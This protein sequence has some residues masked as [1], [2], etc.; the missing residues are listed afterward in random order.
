MSIA[1]PQLQQY[2]FL[3][4]MQSDAYFPPFLVAK[5]RQILIRLCE[6]IEAEP[7]PSLDALYLLTHAAT[8]EF[9]RLAAEFERH[10]S[11]IETAAR[12]NI[13]GDFEVI[14]HAY[15]FDSAD[16]EELIA[17]RDW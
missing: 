5:G 2:D 8:E 10:D 14:A 12:E 17:P 15:G 4:D 11:E 3:A 6:A 1:N 7:P 13:G 9:N 16:V